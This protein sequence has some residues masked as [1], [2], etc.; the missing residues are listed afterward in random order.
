MNI[1]FGLEK[2]NNFLVELEESGKIL[3]R[4]LERGFESGES[5][6]GGGGIGAG[7]EPGGLRRFPTAEDVVTLYPGATPF[8]WLTV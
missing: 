2:R 5:E 6:V 8:C 1:Y 4:T 7:E 3:R